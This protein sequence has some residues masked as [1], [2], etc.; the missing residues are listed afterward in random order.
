M[1]RSSNLEIAWTGGEDDSYVVLYGASG[2][3]ANPPLI[4]SFNCAA[5]AAA[6]RFVVPRDILA[7]MIPSFAVPGPFSIPTGQL[8]VIHYRFPA[9]FEAPG[10]DVGNI[11]F[12]V[13]D[14]ILLNY[15]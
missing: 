9:K 11:S 8:A 15:Q 13:W 2:N 5:R 1:N 7:S 3:G 10:I 4:T 12:Y 14:A 6:G